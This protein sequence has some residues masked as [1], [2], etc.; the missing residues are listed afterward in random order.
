MK[1]ILAT[2]NPSKLEEFK[3]ILAPLGF[4][5]VSQSDAGFHFQVEETGKTFAENAF[6]K[7][8]AIYKETGLPTIADDSG[9]VV[10]ALKGAPGVYSA[11]YAG[12]HATDEQ[13]NQKLLNDL[14]YVG[15]EDRQAKFVCS[16]CYIDA[17]GEAHYTDGVC[18]GRIGFAERGEN[19]FG[20]DPLFYTNGKSFAEMTDAEK[21]RISHRGRAL[22]QLT[23][24]IRELN[25]V[26]IYN[27]PTK[28]E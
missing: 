9:L 19:G 6:L 3:R 1:L 20:Y 28:G 12:E 7:A 15:V 21:D 13:N 18:E 23:E 25:E 2:N 8:D 16:I 22:V 4:E 5:V 11:R 14:I 10:K 26:K 27:P 17:Y 24:M